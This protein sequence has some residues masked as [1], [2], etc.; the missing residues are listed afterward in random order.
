MCCTSLKTDFLLLNTLLLLFLNTTGRQR[1]MHQYYWKMLEKSRF[2]VEIINDCSELEAM[3][4]EGSK[5]TE[6]ER[7]MSGEGPFYL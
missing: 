3:G 1:R 2:L 5:P 4:D 7:G 6:R